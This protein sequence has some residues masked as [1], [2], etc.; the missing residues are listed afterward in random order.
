MSVQIYHQSELIVAVDK[1]LSGLIQASTDQLS[2]QLTQNLNATI[3]VGQFLSKQMSAQQQQLLTQLVAI[4]NGITLLSAQLDTVSGQLSNLQDSANGIWKE[5]TQ[6]ARDQIELEYKKSVDHILI[7]VDKYAPVSTNIDALL[8]QAGS[9]NAH[10]NIT[11][12]GDGITYSGLMDDLCASRSA[13]A[14]SAVSGFSSQAT[15]WPS[16]AQQ[17]LLS[18]YH[19]DLVY[20]VLPF[21]VQNLLGVSLPASDAS[22]VSYDWSNSPISNPIQYAKVVNTYLEA[23]MVFADTFNQGD[24]V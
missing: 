4:I 15:T 12:T 10:R 21:V 19:Y 16:V 8:Q 1:H 6:I 11:N 18:G 9:P 17:I 14:V 13:A 23:R 2:K 24:T 3:Q 20:G 5:N 22:G 7:I